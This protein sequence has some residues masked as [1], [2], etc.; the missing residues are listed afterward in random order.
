MDGTG[1]HGETEGGK[2][3]GCVDGREARAHTNGWLSACGVPPHLCVLVQ[4]ETP[5]V[6]SGAW[7]AVKAC[8]GILVPGGFGE[9]GIEGKIA[10]IAYAREN[11]ARSCPVCALLVCLSLCLSPL[12]LPLR[13]FSAFV[14]LPAC[15]SNAF[16]STCTVACA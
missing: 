4:A 6:Y 8:S 7:A 12:P 10:A 15:V 13:L 9:R 1:R 14:L 11:K 16:S 3:G 5:D 2:E